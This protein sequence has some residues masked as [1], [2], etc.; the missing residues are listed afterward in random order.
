MYETIKTVLRGRAYNLKDMLD[1]IKAFWVSGDVTREQYLELINLA[2]ENA[3]VDGQRAST[4]RQISAIFDNLAELASAIRDLRLRV[5]ALEN[6]SGEPAP[7]E[8]PEEQ[9][10]VPAWAE[11]SGVGEIK[12]QI[13]SVCA[14]NGKIWESQVANNIWEP[15]A[16]GVYENIWK[17]VTE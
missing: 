16:P 5:E 6:G 4:D 10:V 11:W 15:G 7:V 3:T 13:G 9:Q 17:E 14:H 8:D 12:W 1:K 2:N